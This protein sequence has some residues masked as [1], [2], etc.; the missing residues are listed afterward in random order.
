MTIEQEKRL[1]ATTTREEFIRVLNE[2][3]APKTIDKFTEKVLRH[4]DSF[5]SHTNTSDGDSDPGGFSDP[6]VSING[7]P[8]K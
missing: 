3:D 7:K 6:I 5:L 8:V 4:F 1:L 2:T